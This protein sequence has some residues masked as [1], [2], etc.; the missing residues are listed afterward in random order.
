M[1]HDLRPSG[2]SEDF[3]TNQQPFNYSGN[4]SKKTSLESEDHEIKHEA[5]QFTQEITEEAVKK[6]GFM[7]VVKQILG[8]G[9]LGKILSNLLDKILDKQYSKKGKNES[10]EEIIQ[11]KIAQAKFIQKWKEENVLALPMLNRVKDKKLVLENYRMNLGISKALREAIKELSEY[12]QVLCLESNDMSDE[13][14]SSNI[15]TSPFRL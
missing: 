15:Y 3:R 13:A 8:S 7:K 12:L 9:V 14:L 4:Y 2:S 6:E 1:F 11:S 5:R 10:K